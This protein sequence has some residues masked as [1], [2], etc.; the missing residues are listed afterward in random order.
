MNENRSMVYIYDYEQ[1]SVTL[2]GTVPY[3]RDKQQGSTT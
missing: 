3:A 1:V 2:D